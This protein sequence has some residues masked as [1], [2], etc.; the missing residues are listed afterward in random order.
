MR[1]DYAMADDLPIHS[2]EHVVRVERV[3]KAAPELV[4]GI[5][6][7]TNRWNRFVGSSPTVY[8]YKTLDSGRRVREGRADYRGNPMVWTER[9]EWLETRYLWGER[10]FSEALIERAGLRVHLTEVDEGTQ[11][12]AEAYSAGTGWVAQAVHWYWKFVYGR[13]LPAYL[14]A[15]ETALSGLKTRSGPATNATRMALALSDL[16]ALGDTVTPID[17]DGL[18]KGIERMR[19]AGVSEVLVARLRKHLTERPDDAV[20]DM[21]PLELA[22]VWGTDA[23][24]TLG[25][26]LHGT[27]AGLLR[28]DWQIDCPTCRVKADAAD[29]LGSLAEQVHCNECNIRFDVDFDAN[30]EAVFTVHPSVRPVQDVVYC[31]GSAWVRPHVFAQVHVGPGESRTLNTELPEGALL[32]RAQGFARRVT[33]LDGARGLEITLSDNGI[34]AVEGEP[35]TL[36]VHNPTGHRSEVH[37]ERAGWEADVARGR[38]LATLPEFHDLFSAEAPAAGVQLTIGRLTVLFTDLVGSTS[39]YTERGDAAAFALVQKH[40]AEA[41]RVIEAHEG[42]IVKTMGD[43][44][45]ASF[46]RAED[47]VAAAL[48]LGEAMEPLGLQVRV[49]VHEGPCLA[50]RAND[51]FDLFGST[52]NIAARLEGLADGGE[53][54]LLRGLYDFEPVADLVGSDVDSFETTLPGIEGIQHCIR[55]RKIWQTGLRAAP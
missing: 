47:G 29:G 35:G 27:K 54:V 6:S 7:D 46:D 39:L 32:V 16:E 45:M 8:S 10:T 17:V 52:V 41:R 48:E 4:W 33:T 34:E 51:R 28:M 18:S 31:A 14:D 22:K 9:G 38:L 30:V 37:V 24:Q 3:L 5:L 2:P 26:F 21:R 13:L 25:A 12:K 40:F 49:G 53:V 19:G 42:A 44:V 36:V 50:V 23:R 20:R 1:Y 43:A 15:V 55:I 11:V